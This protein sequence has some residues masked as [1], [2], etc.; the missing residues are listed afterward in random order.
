MSYRSGCFNWGVY[1][2]LAFAIAAPGIYSTWRR[3]AE[4]GNRVYL[5]YT[6]RRNGN[7]EPNGAMSLDPPREHCWD[8]ERTI[9][10]RRGRKD[11]DDL[12][13]PSSSC[14]FSLSLLNRSL[15]HCSFCLTTFWI[16]TFWSKTQLVWAGGLFCSNNNA[17]AAT[18]DLCLFARLNIINSNEYIERF[19]RVRDLWGS[20]FKVVVGRCYLGRNCVRAGLFF[21]CACGA[22]LNHID[23]IN[24]VLEEILS[25]RRTNEPISGRKFRRAT[26]P[27]RRFS[28]ETLRKA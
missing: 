14:P 23:F 13:Q 18:G 28:S 26:D 3:N 11:F 15:E 17:T 2:G 27:D 5:W 9:I 8:M 25:T 16:R 1:L 24:Y 19:K 12:R 4:N 20:A 7:L 10:F 6:V 21:S 22:Y